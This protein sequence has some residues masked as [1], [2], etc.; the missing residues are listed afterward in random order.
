LFDLMSGLAVIESFSKSYAASDAKRLNQGYK[1]G[2][3][4]RVT[5]LSVIPCGPIP[6]ETG[7]GS[8]LS[9]TGGNRIGGLRLLA[10]KRGLG[11]ARTQRN[12]RRRGISNMESGEDR[13]QPV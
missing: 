5:N 8:F 9:A 10:I 3:Q 1:I 12:E 2:M 6:P 7:R 13:E 4:P 11:R